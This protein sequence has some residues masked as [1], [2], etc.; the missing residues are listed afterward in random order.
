MT[1]SGR[2]SP[3]D[4]TAVEHEEIFALILA[5]GDHTSLSSGGKSMRS[6]A[7]I[8]LA[9]LLL[10]AAHAQELYD[11]RLS[12]VPI[13]GRQLADVGGSGKLE[14]SLARSQLTIAGTFEGL[15]S[16]AVSASLREGVATGA[17]GPV[18]AELDVTHNNSGSISGEVRLD[19]GQLA[20][21]RE[22]RLYV[23][24]H[25][26]TGVEPDNAVLWG[27]LLSGGTQR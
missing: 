19:R 3:A 11:G 6:I 23:Q 27:W 9:A 22:G 21:L 20:A 10:T 2:I 15:P 12:W 18:I 8:M 1:Q 4:A 14:A 24:L 26:E 13:S 7:S 16:A 25:A 17:R 5:S